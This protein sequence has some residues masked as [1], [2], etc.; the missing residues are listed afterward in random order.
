MK[1]AFE[2]SRELRA[3]LARQREFEERARIF[4]R[5]NGIDPDTL[6]PAK[7]TTHALAS[8]PL[9][10]RRHGPS[11]VPATNNVLIRHVSD[12]D[13]LAES[14]LSRVGLDGADIRDPVRR[15]EALK[16]PIHPLPGAGP[17]D[18]QT[19]ECLRIV[20]IRYSGSDQFIY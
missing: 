7:N 11:L 17:E 16:W 19:D 14:V 1:A 4:L 13:A 12:P 2:E 8:S 10:P 18:G 3:Q 15:P 20:R 9:A 5:E 6:E